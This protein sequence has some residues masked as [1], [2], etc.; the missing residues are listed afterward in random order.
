MEALSNTEWIALAGII[1]SV[2]LFSIELCCRWYLPR[3]ELRKREEKKIA[4][5]KLKEAYAPLYEILRR[6]Y[7]D[8]GVRNVVRNMNP[9][10][11]LVLEETEFTEVC[12]IVQ[13]FGYHLPLQLQ[14]GFTL[15]LQKYDNK[16]YGGKKYCRFELVD[17]NGYWNHIFRMHDELR[18]KLER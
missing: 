2:V 1:V 16:D 7:F 15:A 12:N 3:Q 10:K 18:R 13:N 4:E 11:P 8:N 9:Y 14:R 6:A 5:K 17:F